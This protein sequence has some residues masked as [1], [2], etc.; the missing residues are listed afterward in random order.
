MFNRNPDIDVPGCHVADQL[1]P[2]H[3]AWISSDSVSFL[4]I[5]VAHLNIQWRCL[6]HHRIYQ[7]ARLKYALNCGKSL[8]SFSAPAVCASCPLGALPAGSLHERRCIAELL[9]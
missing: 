8:A 3:S 6:I 1:R 5:V 7:A 2:L 9:V 4:Q